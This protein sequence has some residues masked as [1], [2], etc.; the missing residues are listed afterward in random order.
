[1]WEVGCYLLWVIRAGDLFA[2]APTIRGGR[3]RPSPPLFFSF[4]FY[5]FQFQF[6]FY[7]LVGFLCVCVCVVFNLQLSC[8]TCDACLLFSLG[9]ANTTSNWNLL[10]SFQ[11]SIDLMKRCLFLF[12][13]LHLLSF[14][15]IISEIVRY[16]LYGTLARDERLARPLHHLRDEKRKS[17]IK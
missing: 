14:L 9:L 13:C 15:F 5:I 7:S 11:T 16:L 8:S 3:R 4:S 1:M 6:D 17:P 12:I 2:L 10:F